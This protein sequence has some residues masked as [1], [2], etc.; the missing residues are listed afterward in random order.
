MDAGFRMLTIVT[1]IAVL[2]VAYF[3]I[4]TFHS[5]DARLT[6]IE[7]SGVGGLFKPAEK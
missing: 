5:I 2:A 7:V 6:N 4:R 3:Q 1:A